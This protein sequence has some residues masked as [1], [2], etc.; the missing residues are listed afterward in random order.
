MRKKDCPLGGTTEGE[1]KKFLHWGLPRGGRRGD[2][3][4]KKL[5]GTL[6]WRGG[7][8]LI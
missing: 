3:M 5:I 7:L 4:E 8:F 2:L 1:R 6:R